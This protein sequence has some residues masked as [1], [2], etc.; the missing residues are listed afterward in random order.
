MNGV[1][2]IVLLCLT[3]LAL[4]GLGAPTA[5]AAQPGKVEQPRPQ[6]V[7]DAPANDPPKAAASTEVPTVKLPRDVIYVLRPEVVEYPT[8]PADYTTSDVGNWLTVAFPKG[9]E[10][11][12][13]PALDGAEAFRAELQRDLG[14][15]VLERVKVRV[16]RTPDD[17][18][19][20]AP[21]GMPP[22]DYAVGVSYNGLR[23]VMITLQAPKSFEGSDVTS[24]FQHEL[25]HVALDDAFGNRHIPRWFNEGYAS[26]RAGEGRMH[27]ERL[28][29]AVY[30]HTLIP[31][32]ELDL[33]F[34]DDDNYQLS[35]AY[36]EGTDF[37]RF[38]LRDGER[39]RSLIARARDG[40]TFDRAMTDAYG[41]EPR[42]LEYQWKKELESKDGSLAA[43]MTGSLLWVF[44]FFALVVGYFRRKKKHKAIVAEWEQEEQLAAAREAKAAAAAEEDFRAP[45]VYGIPKVEHEGDW[46]TLH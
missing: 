1:R 23:F 20:L 9:T 35:V 7:L 12:M 43:I 41:V 17:M 46:H 38:L 31:L 44:G 40:A 33:R 15:N 32:S 25:T 8:L 10:E 42:T 45:P 37:V 27:A 6:P 3:L 2:R 29:D 16:A 5:T 24:V 36:A 4:F 13:K 21:K 22:P 28:H 11:R 26:L 30:M 19:A 34:P 39:F 18:R 14:S